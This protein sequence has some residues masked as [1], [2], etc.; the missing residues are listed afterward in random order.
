MVDLY[1]QCESHLD[2]WLLQSAVIPWI[3]LTG[4]RGSGRRLWAHRKRL[5]QSGTALPPSRFPHQIIMKRR[6]D[7]TGQKLKSKLPSKDKEKLKRACSTGIAV[8]QTT[9]NVIEQIAGNVGPPGLQAGIKGLI[10]V[11]D[12][13]QVIHTTWG[14]CISNSHIENVPKRT[15]YR[16]AYEA[17]GWPAFS[18]SECQRSWNA[19]RGNTF[20]NWLL[21]GVCSLV[22]YRD[23]TLLIFL[24]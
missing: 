11:L 13:A 2:G 3:I 24:Q 21:I 14:A 12:V 19:L 16:A 17:Y 20:S 9:L 22:F 7:A 18:S 1:A 15:G 5:P 4:F 8:L 10:L 6:L 23:L